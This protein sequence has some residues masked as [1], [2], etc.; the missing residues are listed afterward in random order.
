MLCHLHCWRSELIAFRCVPKWDRHR[1]E[2]EEL[3]GGRW[4]AFQNKS[5][6]L[7]TETP[8]RW[9]WA[10]QHVQ[11]I[12]PR[13]SSRCCEVNVYRPMAIHDVLA[14]WY[15]QMKVTFHFSSAQSCAY[16]STSWCIKC[17]DWLVDCIHHIPAVW[18]RRDQWRVRRSHARHICHRSGRSSC[19]PSIGCCVQSTCHLRPPSITSSQGVCI[20]CKS[21]FGLRD[22]AETRLMG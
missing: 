8:V 10:F 16:W 14:L 17:I 6:R 7:V 1:R 20:R 12:H 22:W 13:L 19:T 2:G 11:Q 21:A 9:E 15:L 3:R 4:K 18:S 5:A